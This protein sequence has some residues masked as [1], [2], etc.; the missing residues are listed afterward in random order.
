MRWPTRMFRFVTKK[1]SHM[2]SA[3]L[4]SFTFSR[5][6]GA[7]AALWLCC[8][9]PAWA[10]DGG[11][12][13][14][15]INT[16]LGEFCTLL[17]GFPYFVPLP[18]CPQVPTVTQGILQL[19]AG[20]LVPP[21]MVRA[22]NNTPLGQAVDTGNP[23]LP[24]ATLPT[25]PLTTAI[26][27]FPVVGTA[28]SNLLP[29][30]TPLAFISS[31]KSPAAVAQLYNSNADI[32]LSAVASGFL[33][34]GGQPDTVFFFYDDPRQIINI[35]LPGQV[36]ADIS[37]PLVVLTGYPS[38]PTE[39]PVSGGAT[40]KIVV[41]SKLPTP[42]SGVAV[43]CSASTV[44]GNFSGK[45]TQTL[46]AAQIGVNCAVVFAPSPI[47]PISHAIYEVQV[48]LVVTAATDPLYFPNLFSVIA[49]PFMTDDTGFPPLP[50]FPSGNGVFP[51]GASIGLP[52]FAAPLGPPPA[53][54]V[55]AAY[56]LCANLPGLVGAPVPAVAAFY[57]IS[58]AGETLLSAPLPS[59][60]TSV[61][62]F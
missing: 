10:G 55:A 21:V 41:P 47:S 13:A 49:S 56:A 58:T 5:L 6:A 7:V 46:S 18:P 48:P 35:L 40:L 34:H 9:G 24:P 59:S 14:G 3:S 51:T 16:A 4:R 25:T 2:V 50:G 36:I 12:D 28:L 54:G 17:E 45:G 37:L 52:P 22:T 39:T 61:C 31:S 23:S 32:F 57:A 60:S 11:N 44:T 20:L 42:G 43:N 15:T 62:P 29:A 27:A 33:D 8:A 1:G 26:T 30:L 53:A 19:A 38:A